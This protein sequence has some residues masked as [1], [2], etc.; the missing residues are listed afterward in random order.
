MKLVTGIGGVFI[1]AKDPEVLC[2][3]Y[4]AHLD[5]DVQDWGATAFCWVDDTGSAHAGTTIWSVGE[6]S[7]FSRARPPIW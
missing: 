5:I 1:R 6:G 7:N 3:W 4:K 2:D